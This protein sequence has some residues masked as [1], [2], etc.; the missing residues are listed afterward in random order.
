MGKNYK[1]FHNKWI[2][3]IAIGLIVMVSINLGGCY[4]PVMMLQPSGRIDPGLPD[5]AI[6]SLVNEELVK[7]GAHRS[8]LLGIDGPVR[9]IQAGH[10]FWRPYKS[11]YGFVHLSILPSE[12]SSISAP[13]MLI[14]TG[15]IIKY[16]K[17][18]V[19]K[20]HQH[21]TRDE[22]AGAVAFAMKTELAV[23]SIAKECI[24]SLPVATETIRQGWSQ[25]LERIDFI[26]NNDPSFGSDSE[27]QVW[28]SKSGD[29]PAAVDDRLVIDIDA[30][31]LEI[32]SIYGVDTTEI[33]RAV[34]TNAGFDASQAT[35]DIINPGFER[36]LPEGV[37]PELL[38]AHWVV[39][40]ID[41]KGCTNPLW[42]I[43]QKNTEKVLDIFEA[44]DP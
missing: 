33:A 25:A 38:R 12:H 21:L 30:D 43:V 42:V 4:I 5:E 32:N 29:I 31:T 23:L 14:H 36:K 11:R 15:Y 1:E 18:G 13:I 34:I 37:T 20:I 6:K 3:M 40:A 9:S 10:H 44:P 8:D 19:V 22:I 26:Y 41:V 27:W 16:I 39:R 28:F 24:L 35:L 2:L 17:K 7:I